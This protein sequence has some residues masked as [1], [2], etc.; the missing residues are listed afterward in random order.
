ME[1][2]SRTY[3][4]YFLA[5]YKYARQK[6]IVSVTPV[7]ELLAIECGREAHPMEAHVVVLIP[8]AFTRC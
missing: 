5:K 3:Y 6:R 8:N 1:I 4:Y 2:L 7:D